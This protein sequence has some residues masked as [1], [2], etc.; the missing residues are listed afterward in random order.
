MKQFELKRLPAVKSIE[1][2]LKHHYDWLKRK[3]KRYLPDDMDAWLRE[4]INKR[5]DIALSLHEPYTLEIKQE[6]RNFLFPR[7]KLWINQGGRPLP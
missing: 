4:E 5:A 3:G 1:H 7:L 6:V 2:G